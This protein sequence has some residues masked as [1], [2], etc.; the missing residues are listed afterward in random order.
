MDKQEI[1]LIALASGVREEFSP[2]QLQKLMFLID[3]NIGQSLGG[4]FF[5]FEPYDYGPFDVDVYN[6]FSLL[7]A[8]QLAQSSGQGKERRYRL[9]DEGRVRADEL[10]RRLSDNHRQYVIDLARLVQSLSFT[11]LVSSIYKAYPEMKVNSVFR[12]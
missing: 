7:E 1:L 9:N 8:Q 12:G 2:V 6:S 3:R 10:K 4:P 5:R 11:A